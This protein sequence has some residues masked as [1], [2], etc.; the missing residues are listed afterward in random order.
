MKISRL[1]KINPLRISEKLI[2]NGFWKINLQKN[3][4]YAAYKHVLQLKPDNKLLKEI[5]VFEERAL[6]G[7]PVYAKGWWKKMILRYGIAAHLSRNK[8]VLDTCSGLGW[9][10][11]LISQKAGKVVSID[12]DE[13]SLNFARKYWGEKQS[14]IDFRKASVL[15][16]PFDDN[17]YDVVIAMESIE[18]FTQEDGERYFNEC[19]RVLKKG[20]ILFGSSAFPANRKEADELCAKNPYHYYVYTKKEIKS[21]LK[22]NFRWAYIFQNRLYFIAKK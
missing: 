18:H 11:Y 13:L 6:P 17:T 21:L 12:I 15:D 4:F 14:N 16:I 9:G 3:P 20:G 8:Y 1:E 10:S 2:I 19:Y 7:D 22:R 5:I